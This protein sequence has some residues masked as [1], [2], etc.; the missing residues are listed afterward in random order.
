VEVAAGEQQRE[1]VEGALADRALLDVEDGESRRRAVTREGEGHRSPK[2]IARRGFASG[3]VQRLTA[4]A[5]R[6]CA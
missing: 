2:R 1:G 6:A 3:A 4:N 5:V